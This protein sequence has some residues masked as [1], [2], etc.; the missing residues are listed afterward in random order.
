MAPVGERD[1]LAGDRASARAL[2]ADVDRA[3]GRAH[4]GEGTVERRAEQAHRPAAVPLE[5]QA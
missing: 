1:R 5:M 3:D 2:I 4:V